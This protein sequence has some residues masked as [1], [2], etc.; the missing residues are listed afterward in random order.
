MPKGWEVRCLGDV[1]ENPRWGVRSDQIA[2]NT[3]YIALEHMPRRCIALSEW[4]T[5]EGLESGKFQFR[6]GDMLFGKLRPY[7]HKVG[8]A[9]V[10]GVCSTDILVVVPCAPEW[11]G[12]VLGH[13][14][15]DAFV[16]HTNAGSTGTKMPRTSWG[17]MARFPLVIPPKPVAETFT[18]HMRPAIDG[19]IARVHES[20]T[21]AAMRDALLPKLLSGDVRINE[22]GREAAAHA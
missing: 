14:S 17:D 7:F 5:A 10:G 9:P 4:G 1:A 22:V 15:S 3:P 2:P 18:R 21:L 13:I 20:R 6:I 11:F 12:F 8:V 19:I 16:E